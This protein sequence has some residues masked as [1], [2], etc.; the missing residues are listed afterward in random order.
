MKSK[1]ILLLYYILSLIIC[2]SNALKC[3]EEEI[4]NCLQ[5]GTGEASNTC[6]KCKDKH[7]LFFNNMFCI[8]CDDPTY[9]QIG[10]GGNCD[11]SHYNQ[12]RNV[13]YA[14]KMLARKVIIIWKDFA[15]VALKVLMDAKSA[16]LKLVIIILMKK[17]INVQN[18]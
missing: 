4:D 9:G 14:K 6:L 15:I 18:V 5:C 1:N 8:P 16:Q 7:F 13:F 3:G 10:C 17:Y 2:K 12:F 11:S